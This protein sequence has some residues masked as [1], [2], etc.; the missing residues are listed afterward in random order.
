VPGN[1]DNAVRMMF[2]M[3]KEDL[4]K[5]EAKLEARTGVEEKGEENLT[6]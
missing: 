2:S 6:L 1:A 4:L 3:L 5:A